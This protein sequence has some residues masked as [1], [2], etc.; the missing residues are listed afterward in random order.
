[1]EPLTQ[2]NGHLAMH[3]ALAYSLT[4]L[5]ISTKV[6]STC[7]WPTDHMEFS[8]TLLATSTKDRGSRIKSMAITA[9]SIGSKTILNTE[10]NI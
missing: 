1:M 9:E 7:L 5:E 6:H 10:V 2:G 8:Q 4:N 3:M